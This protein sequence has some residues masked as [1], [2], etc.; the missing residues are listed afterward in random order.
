M[1]LISL[2]CPTCDGAQR[3]P[4]LLQSVLRQTYDDWEL[5]V[6]DNCSQDNTREVLSHYK[7]PRIRVTGTG[8]RLLLGQHLE[9]AYGHASGQYQGHIG[10]DDV[11]SPRRM[12]V[13]AK[14]IKETHSDIVSIPHVRSYWEDYP[15]TTLA[16]TTDPCMFSGNVTMC[17]A[18]QYLEELFRNPVVP[19]GGRFVVHR[20]IIEAVRKRAGV[21]ATSQHVEFFALRAAA[22]LAKTHVHIDFPFFHLGR[23]VTSAGEFYYALL[24]RKRFDPD[25][26][27]E[28]PEPFRN[29]P[30]QIKVYGAVSYDALCLV[31]KIFHEETQHLSVDEQVYAERCLREVLSRKKSGAL[32]SAHWDMW[33]QYEKRQPRAIRNRLGKIRQ[34]FSAAAKIRKKIRKRIYALFGKGKKSSPGDLLIMKGPPYGWRSRLAWKDIGVSN[35]CEFAVWMETTYSGVIDQLLSSSLYENARDE[36]EAARKNGN[37]A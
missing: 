26:D 16:G 17:S 4:A 18:R 28:D 27:F 2:V 8:K 14:T 6:S 15:D 19:S 23:N 33:L 35:L 25:M 10:D 36:F 7:D 29:S 3:L 21:Y 1:A 37:E 31:K 12:E 20:D 32:P 34:E 30:F 5:V 22:C 13:F 24:N 9:F 11:I